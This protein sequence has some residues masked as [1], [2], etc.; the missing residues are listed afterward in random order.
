MRLRLGVQEQARRADPVTGQ[1][2]HMG[3]QC[4]LDALGIAVDHAVCHASGLVDGDLANTGL[5]AQIDAGTDRVRPISNVGAAVCGY[6]SQPR[7]P[8]AS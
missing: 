4:L 1:D 5:R 8:L 3:F 2:D 7:Y 6:V